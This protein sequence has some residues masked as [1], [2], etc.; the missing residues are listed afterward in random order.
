[1]T[2]RAIQLLLGEGVLLGNHELGRPPLQLPDQVAHLVF[3]V[4][5][6]V[7][8][9]V[10]L[11]GGGHRSVQ[12]KPSNLSEAQAVIDDIR[13]ANSTISIPKV[14]NQ[15]TSHDSIGLLLPQVDHV[16]QH[17][18]QRVGVQVKQRPIVKIKNFGAARYHFT[19]HCFLQHLHQT[20]EPFLLKLFKGKL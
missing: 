16:H 6:G 12:W 3:H 9:Q 14:Y 20:L 8:G 2:C 19:K 5:G 11:E 13:I 17:A 7:Q 10:Q 15:S 18:L 1:M 4:G